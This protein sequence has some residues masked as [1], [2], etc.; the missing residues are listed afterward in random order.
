[1]YQEVV[2]KVVAKEALTPQMIAAGAELT[3]R[4]DEVG[5]DLVA[6]FWL[7]TAESNQWLLVLASP[8]VT[9]AGPVKAY[10][11]IRRVLYNGATE[12]DLPM[13]LWDTT[14][15]EDDDPLIVA[16]RAG[17]KTRKKIDGKRYTETIIN[18]QF[19]EDAYVYRVS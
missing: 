7:Y 8:Y 6:S 4:L 13:I 11:R 14:V 16:L 17:I 9:T 19:T 15:R 12:P 3:R 18:G 2:V 1:M 10:R 5:F